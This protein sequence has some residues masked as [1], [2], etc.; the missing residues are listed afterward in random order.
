MSQ[1]RRTDDIC[2]SESGSVCHYWRTPDGVGAWQTTTR[3]RHV[4]PTKK[5][6][7]FLILTPTTPTSTH[8]ST[9]PT[10]PDRPELRFRWLEDPNDIRCRSGKLDGHKRYLIRW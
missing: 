9:P 5:S 7:V 4:T 2:Q 10:L 3:S 6:S 8:H 1:H